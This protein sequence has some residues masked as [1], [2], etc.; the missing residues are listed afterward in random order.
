MF[1]PKPLTFDEQ[2]R[3]LV[4]LNDTLIRLESIKTDLKRC[5]APD[6]YYNFKLAQDEI[7]KFVAE[8]YANQKPIA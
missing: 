6:E 5:I 4:L 8:M 1:M 3:V 2:H 7:R